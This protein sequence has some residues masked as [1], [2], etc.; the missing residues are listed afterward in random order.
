MQYHE[1]DI[2]TQQQ[3]LKIAN[4]MLALLQ[5]CYKRRSWMHFSTITVTG[6]TD[7]LDITGCNSNWNLKLTP[8][9]N[10]PPKLNT[11]VAIFI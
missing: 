11:Y 9:L 10:H 5:L 3:M 1:I 7:L 6:D 8:L 2:P 4:L